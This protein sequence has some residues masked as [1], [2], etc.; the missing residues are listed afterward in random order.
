MPSKIRDLILK[1]NRPCSNG[2]CRTKESR[3]RAGRPDSHPSWR[4]PAMRVLSVTH[5]PGGPPW[6]MKT[7]SVSGP[8]GRPLLRGGGERRVDRISDLRVCR[9]GGAFST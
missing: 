9:D 3:A 4:P 7:G 5:G 2:L 8:L 6:R 1:G